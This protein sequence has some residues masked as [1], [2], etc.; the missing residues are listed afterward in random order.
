MYAPRSVSR[1]AVGLAAGGMA[2]LLAAGCSGGS[3]TSAG[4]EPSAVRTPSGAG[5]SPGTAPASAT[6]TPPPITAADWPTYHHDAARSGHAPSA[7]PV[8]RL[9]RAWAAKLDGAVYAQPLLI[10]DTVIAAT[11]NDTLYALDAANGRQ[12][13]RT[14]VGTP[15][16]LSSLP[17][18]NIDPLGITGTP[19]Y[20]PA[21][22]RVFALAEVS[23]RH[24][25]LVGV[26]LVS[27]HVDVRQPLEPPAGNP[28]DAQQRSALTLM[29]DRVYVAYGGL[30]G[31]CGQYI[32]GVASLRTDG[33]GRIGWAV[34]TAR[35]GGIWTPG[36]PAVRAGS[37]YVS[38]GNGAATSG[39]YDGS[40]SITRL[41]PGLRRED[42]FAPRQW[43]QDNAVDADLGSMGA[44]LIG[45]RVVVAGKSG[46]AYL[47]DTNH[48]GGIGGQLGT[49]KLGCAGFGAAAVVGSTAYLPCRSGIRQVTVAGSSLTPG[50]QGPSAAKGPPVVGG[51]AVF[52]VDPD[53]GTVFALDPSTGAVRASCDVGSVAHFASPALSG[54]RAF[55]PTTNGVVALSTS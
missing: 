12:R 51:G 13:W 48:L 35:M 50:W 9:S 33:T 4:G 2:L 47:L 21:T 28:A 8:R 41:S 3:T 23:G 52:S 14:S 46:I 38:I 27:G 1:F 19:V 11:E 6:R 29:G 39:D 49:V 40:D 22:G 5:P 36:G 26:D 55:V 45:D 42:F 20:D 44:A 10:G 32:G 30:A 31:D 7:T 53:T 24:H 18:G 25:V 16:P 34:P 37:L 54:S 15:V 17:C 43:A